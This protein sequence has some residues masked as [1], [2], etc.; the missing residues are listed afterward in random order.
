MTRLMNQG[1]KNLINEGKR[2]YNVIKQKRKIKEY[3]QLNR[4]V[5]SWDLKEDR[6]GANLTLCGNAFQRV[7]AAKAKERSP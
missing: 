5:L 3:Q 2:S 1:K 4:N 6:E 7:A